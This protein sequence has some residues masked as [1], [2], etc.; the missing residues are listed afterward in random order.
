VIDLELLDRHVA[1][2]LVRKF[3]HPSGK[4][5][6]FNYTEQCTY[7]GAWDAVTRQC[8]GLILDPVGNIVARPFPKFFNFGEPS[9]PDL[10]LDA[11]VTATDK[12]DGSLGIIYPDVGGVCP[13][14]GGERAYVTDTVRARQQWACT[15]LDCEA[16]YAKAWAVAT[17]GSFASDQAVWAT[18][19]LQKFPYF[20]NHADEI[21]KPGWTYLVEIIYPANRI[22]VDYGDKEM[23]VLLGAVENATGNI[24][25]AHDLQWYGERADE[26]AR[27]VPL[28]D[29]LEIPPRPNA[30]G[31]VV[32]L[33]DH[34][35]VK[36]KQDD[37]VRIHRIVF[38][39]TARRVWEHAGVQTLSRLGL[40]AKQIGIAMLMDPDEVAGMI[41]DGETGGWM[42]KVLEIVPEEFTN[43]LLSTNANIIHDVQA[44]E[45]TARRFFKQIAVDD[46]NDRK[47]VALA[48]KEEA[49]KEM[50]GALFTLLDGKTVAPLSWRA[51]RPDHE[52]FRRDPDA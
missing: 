49:P 29:V 31:I 44:W 43:W 35:M 28:R 37:Y 24:D 14:C 21:M 38:G 5:F 9:A 48:I 3:E 17:R 16:L 26:I 19:A 45:A 30:E 52:T 11:L 47:T 8:R 36:I 27:G 12:I 34:T 41:K 7:Q 50:H 13:V 22:V 40:D 33:A 51:C 15:T 1:A 32:I 20:N 6:G 2:G 23:L 25:I 10:D 18:D 46:A 42:E 4:L 39:L